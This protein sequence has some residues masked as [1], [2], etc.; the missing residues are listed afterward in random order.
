MSDNGLTREERRCLQLWFRQAIAE[1]ETAEVSAQLIRRHGLSSDDA[2]RHQ[3]ARR[4][5][6]HNSKTLHHKE[7]VAQ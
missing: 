1:V 6:P 7:L 4:R 3:V 2:H 5:V